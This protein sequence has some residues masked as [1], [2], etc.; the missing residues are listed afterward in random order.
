[1]V[2]VCENSFNGD[3]GD[4]I[5]DDDVDE[6]D[7]G[8]SGTGSDR[9]EGEIVAVARAA[10]PWLFVR[11]ATEAPDAKG[12]RGSKCKLSMCCLPQGV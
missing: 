10:A 8:V 11:G 2:A 1:V 3:A 5:Y 9:D 7:R 12:L 4:G 6:H